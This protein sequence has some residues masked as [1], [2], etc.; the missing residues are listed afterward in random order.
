MVGDK[1]S[2]PSVSSS[3]SSLLF[4]QKT[5][6]FLLKLRQSLFVL[7]LIIGTTAKVYIYTRIELHRVA[8]LTCCITTTFTKFLRNNDNN[9]N[10]NNKLNSTRSCEKMY[11]TKILVYIYNL[12]LDIVEIKNK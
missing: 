9:N 11:K 10:E 8:Q 1:Y 6:L 4:N 3:A 7:C 2:Y 5:P 12:F